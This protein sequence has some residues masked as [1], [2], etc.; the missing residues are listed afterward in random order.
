MDYRTL[1]LKVGIEVHQ[2]L[3]TGKFFCSCESDLVEEHGDEFVR[4]LR[5]TQSEMGEIDRAALMEAE[6]KL[7]FRY[8]AVESSC[9]VEADEEPP[10]DANRLAIETALEMSYVLRATP[11]D[12]IH[13]MRK[14]VIDGSNTT[15]FQRTALVATDGY[16][17]LDG[18]RITI[19]AISLE[20]DAA[21]KMSESGS[22]VLYRIDRLGIPL[23]E[24][25]TGPEISTPDEAKR[26][27]A[28]LG[29]LL[30]ATRRVRRGIGTIREDLNISISG[31]ARVEVKG[32]QELRL[33]PVYV[34]TEIRRQLALLE[35][36]DLLR[37]RGAVDVV[38][39]VEDVS[40]V[41]SGSK[42]RVTESA[43]RSGG[44]VY[45]AKLPR[46]AGTLAR[47]DD[48]ILRLGADL[49]AHA[50]VAGVRGLFHSDELPGYGITEEEAAAVAARLGVEDE[51][52]FV[53]IADERARAEAAIQRAVERANA[54]IDGVPEETRAPLPDG[55]TV[56]SRPLPGKARMYPETDVRPI[57]VDDDVL[58]SIRLNLPELPEERVSRFVRE[59]NLSEGQAEALIDDGVDEEFELLASSF[60]GPQVVARIYLQVLPEI[61]KQGRDVSSVDV[62]V[63]K[64]L[65]EKLNDGAFAKEAI[66]DIL[67]WM[68]DNDVYDVDRALD[69]IGLRTADIEMVR[70]V[71]DRI[72]RERED[73]IRKRGEASL[74]P[75]MGVVMKELR[76][77]VDGKIISAVLS[78]RIRQLLP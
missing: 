39:A 3:N 28:R 72:V 34:D 15:G 7:Q 33:L 75:L 13:I 54:A 64:L 18:K 69:G 52:A 40:E 71:C 45:A 78:E 14:M 10:H 5:P 63:L 66:P 9:L 74:G 55:S 16:I 60:G 58:Q 68:V 70:E 30:R 1:G 26:V 11:V 76:G 29:S 2:Q 27:A 17:E 67:L 59:L 50:R 19:E 61:S 6:K 8:E 20:E 32:V 4:R 62:G 47:T 23:V 37:R 46:F 42:C 43:I 35:V 38:C 49:A 31:G 73:F 77:K 25:A 51:D 53:L 41:F 21:R 56:Y 12:E 24:I 65:L 48:G 44:G 22:E 57:R 36:K